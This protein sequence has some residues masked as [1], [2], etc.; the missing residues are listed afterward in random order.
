MIIDQMELPVLPFV[1]TA[2]ATV[3]QGD[4][5]ARRTDPL[6]ERPS[7][8]KNTWKE[9]SCLTGARK[10]STV[11]VVVVF[12]WSRCQLLVPRTLRARIN[13]PLPETESPHH[14]KSRE[15]VTG[16]FRCLI[17]SW[18]VWSTTFQVSGILPRG[19]WNQDRQLRQEMREEAGVDVEQPSQR[20][21]T[22][23]PLIPC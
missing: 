1:D 9:I 17:G 7:P 6:D 21:G 14:K 8:A 18:C 12:H 11:R 4:R 22:C 13:P 10:Y 16:I 3:W 2:N 5:S 20:D 23:P 15:G 19:Q